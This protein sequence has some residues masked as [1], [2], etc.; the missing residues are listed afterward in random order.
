MMNDPVSV[1]RC[2]R[3]QGVV[4]RAER[5]TRVFAGQVQPWIAI[6]YRGQIP[7]PTQMARIRRLRE[8][9]LVLLEQEG[10]IDDAAEIDIPFDFEPMKWF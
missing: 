8:P 7:S 5:T 2:L 4:I 6:V 3:E 9:L 10:C 1:L